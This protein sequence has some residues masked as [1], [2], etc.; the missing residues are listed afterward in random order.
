MTVSY[1]VRRLLVFF[2]IV[3]VAASINFIIPRLAPG[4]PVA[5]MVGRMS[6]QGASVEGSAQI[7]ENYRKQFGLDDP[8]PVQYVKYLWAL[9]RFDLGPSLSNFPTPVSDII[10]RALPWTIGL[11]VIATLIAFTLGSLFGALLVWRATPRAAQLLFPPLM[12]FAAIP[13]YLL[14]IVLL[15]LLAFQ[16]GWLPTGGTARIGASGGWSLD[17]IVD[18]ALHSILPALSIVL[19]AVGGWMLG[20]RAMMVSVI[21]SDYLTLAEAKGLT[22]RRIFM[23][24]AVRNAILPQV[25]GLAISLGTIVSGALL[26]EVIFS[27]PG[28]G[29]LLYRAIQNADYTLIQGITFMLVLAVGIV[30][31]VLDLAYPLLDPRITYQGR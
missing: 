14:A 27:Y 21:G 5:A 10:A 29:F 9:M 20:M 3:W 13:Y 26:V 11:L 8:L 30:I 16:L 2:L 15:Y 12:V 1:L 4:D 22:Q 6:Q 31:L 19:S 23:R 24:Y 17:T 28:V 18:V 7:I 25:T